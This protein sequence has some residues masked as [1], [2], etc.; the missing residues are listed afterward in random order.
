MGGSFTTGFTAIALGASTVSGSGWLQDLD[1]LLQ[2]RIETAALLPAPPQYP[3]V[4][5]R[6][7]VGVS[8]PI[9]FGSLWVPEVS[10]DDHGHDA[11][12]AARSVAGPS[13]P[14]GT[15]LPDF[16]IPEDDPEVRDGA[17]LEFLFVLNVQGAQAVEWPDGVPCADVADRRDPRTARPWAWAVRGVRTQR[18]SVTIMNNVINPERGERASVHYVL[19]GEGTVTVTVFDLKGDIVD[20]LHRGR[21]SKGEYSTTW[22]GRNRGG[23][24]VARG[25]YFIKVVGPGIS[26]TRKG[27]VV[28]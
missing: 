26:E 23:N 10:P 22:D 8:S 12:A 18:G 15:Q 20:V 21:Q 6:F 2:A 19:S 27:L 14:P 7:D 28:R 11:N 13:S 9:R 1:V 24:A 5:L 17:D 3:A 16:L 25:I 4:D